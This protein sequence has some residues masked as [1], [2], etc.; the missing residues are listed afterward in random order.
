MEEIVSWLKN[1]QLEKYQEILIEN[2]FNTI[3]L[4]S[5]LTEDNLKELGFSLGDRKRF[6]IAKKSLTKS[7]IQLSAEDLALIN[8]LP[9]VIAYPLKRTL[10]ESHPWTKINL[11]KDTFENY[12]KYLCLLSASEFFNSEIKDKGM[13]A[14]FH[15]N[16]METTFGKWNQYIRECLSFLKQQ[17]HTFFYPELPAYYELV[18]TGSK[19][20]K[21][22]GEIEYQDG[23]G[24]T[25]YIVQT[26][27]TGIGMLINFRNRFLG[28]G[29]TLDEEKSNALWEEYFSI[30]R[31]LLEQLSFTKDYPMLKREHGETYLLHSA[32][33]TVVESNI[34]SNSTIW[35]QNK[36]GQ[37]F[38]IL[39]FFIVPGEVSLAKEDKEQLLTYQSYT[40]KTIKFFSPEGTEKQTSGKI[41]EKLNLLLRD[42]QKETPFAPEAFTKDEFLKRIAEENKLLLDTLISEKK[43]IP[44]VYQHREEME[45]KLSEWIGARA[46][47]FFIMAEAGSGKTNLLVEIQKQYTERDLP[48]LLIR[49]GRMEKQTLKEQITYLL[50]IDLEKG[51][52]KYASIA[53]TQAE[54]TFILIDGLNEAN[55]A[56]EIWQDIVELCKLFV[57][58]SLKFVVTNRA[59][60]KAELNRYLVSEKNQDLLYGENKDNETG[61]GAYS[62][63]LT[64]LDMQEMKGAWDTYVVKDKARFKP[65][66]S[67]DAIAGFDRGI[68]NQINNPLILRL[69]L[70]I[71]N[72]K[73]LPKKGVKHL[74]I[75]HN[76]LKTF[77]TEE[78][79]F[80]KLVANEV[81]QKGENELL[82]DDLL[83]NEILKPYLA[84][85][86]I[87]AP[88]NRLKNNGWISRY[89]KDLSGYISFTAEGSL[90]FLLALQLYEQKPAIDLTFIQALLK[91]G[92]KL[93]KSAI[94]T[95]LCEHALNGDLNLVAELIDAGNEDIDLCIKPLLLYLKTIGVKVF[96]E[97]VLEN[98]TENDW[99]ALN[100]LDDQLAELQ[101]HVLR[102]EY[103]IAL[104]P[105]NEFKT[106]DSLGLGLKAIAIFDK[107]EAINYLNKVDTNASFIVEDDVLLSQLGNCEYKF[108]NYDKAREYYEKSLAIAL[109]Y[110]GV[111]DIIVAFYYSEIG[112]T[113]ISKGEC[114][115]ALEFFEKCLAIQLKTFGA[116][117]NSDEN[118]FVAFSNLEIGRT[119]FSK[120]E[121]SKAFGEIS[122]SLIEYEKGL[123]FCQKGLAI[124]LKLF[125]EEHPQVGVAYNNIASIWAGKG[126][127][128]KALEY[129]EKCLAI[130][131]KTFG[132][133]HPE[134]AAIYSNIGYIWKSKADGSSD[135]FF[136]LAIFDKALKYFEK[137]LA[138]QLKTLGG[139]HPNVVYSYFVIGETWNKKGEHD[140]ALEFFEKCLAITLKTMGDESPTIAL[141]YDN[142][143]NIW[144]SRGEDYKALEYYEKCLVIRI[145]TFGQEHVFTTAL[146]VKILTIL[147]KKGEYDKV[148]EI[149]AGDIILHPDVVQ[150]YNF[151]G[152]ICYSKGEYDKSLETYEKSLVIQ[153]KTLGG[154]HPDVAISYF[155]IGN[156]NYELKLYSIA[157]DFFKKGFSTEKKGGYPFQIAKCYEALDEKEL[158][159]DY[160]IQSAEIRKEDPGCGLENESTI[161][162]I[163]NTK[164]LAKEIG[165]EKQLPDWMN[166]N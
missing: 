157:I 71:Y 1:N 113:W 121:I 155:N 160:F 7:G 118:I 53:G 115:K 6:A 140:K 98:P 45:I 148:I 32:E 130:N 10:L 107:E 66:F 135:P 120:G 68:Y 91:S 35:I 150:L 4:L 83:K 156:C 158:A 47:I 125:G 65:Q 42:K 84:S 128:D 82:L 85:D 9:Y 39:P 43:I 20:K 64:A 54:P 142:I 62:F 56:E 46:N 164:R 14:L 119:W 147:L 151:F 114:D 101:L 75:W 108:G 92:S 26:S 33:I 112:K 123:E 52:E 81:W 57:P 17:N 141:L 25:Q 79:L 100:K 36:Q 22:K 2:D 24:D 97:K 131:L 144:E 51:L 127:H 48:S 77:S 73:V 103:L 87:N 21:Y 78:Q 110:F 104:M 55:N 154:E 163:A 146:S 89:V 109:E 11:L 63:W 106:K 138:I 86:I 153:L 58:G 161:D 16:L 116:E 80:L 88:Y 117:G 5:E 145:K 69:F 40:G 38:D 143:G 162:S 12:L 74:N 134:V 165:K 37:A 27:V 137:C 136:I 50:N 93:Q 28:H 126:E 67:F 30:F 41:L 29:Q 59:N 159:L 152:N 95:F 72:G 124:L 44:G 149:L 61:L 49:A 19:S 90:L 13:V 31:N 105:Q 76:W 129:F 23:N 102:K 133:E 3:E 8:S 34:K 70:E 111:E 99:K 132:E 96:L 15:K 122:N 18:E 60:T 166:G 139:E 94:E